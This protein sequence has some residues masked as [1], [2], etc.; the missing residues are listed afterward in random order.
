MKKQNDRKIVIVFES[1]GESSY[2]LHCVVKNYIRAF[3]NRVSGFSF[4]LST[5][6]VKGNQGTKLQHGAGY[7]FCGCKLSP[8]VYL[9]TTE[10]KNGVGAFYK[11]SQNNDHRQLKLAGVRS[12]NN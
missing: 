1:R 6:F 4:Q 12:I 8:F 5:H 11:Y 3:F 2:F 10:E 9:K 7:L